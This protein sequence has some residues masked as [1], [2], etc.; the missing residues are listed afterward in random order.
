[1]GDKS[2]KITD[3]L[4]GVGNKPA[5]KSFAETSAGF[6]AKNQYEVAKNSSGN[7][8]ESVVYEVPLEDIDIGDTRFQ[9]RL[10]NNDISEVKK[11]I[12]EEGQQTPVILL[13]MKEHDKLI[14]VSGFTRT[15]AIQELKR[16]IVKATIKTDIQEVDALT[17]AF[18]ENEARKNL[19]DW[20]RI[21]CFVMLVKKGKTVTQVAK[22]IG[23]DHSTVSLYQ[24]VYDSKEP[25]REA[26][27]K[28][29]IN[30][31][32]ANMLARYQ[33]RLNDAQIVEVVSKATELSVQN[34]KNV[35]EE[36]LE[37]KTSVKTAVR[38][39]KEK[40]KRNVTK[41]RNRFAVNIN[42]KKSGEIYK[43]N[44]KFLIAKENKDEVKS[45]FEEILKEIASL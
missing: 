42:F 13:K 9:M 37:N 21:Q 41:R 20:E 28:N 44:A 35:I 45:K 27:K 5:D 43:F 18:I 36:I 11:S 40:P 39:E 3:I 30:F 12:E 33:D 32:K 29:L 31:S 14:I 25:I 7:F 15:R 26:L 2:K 23:K 34:L 4:F 24:K 8:I 1:M 19:T 22:D 16:P 6:L 38:E 10:P 17:I